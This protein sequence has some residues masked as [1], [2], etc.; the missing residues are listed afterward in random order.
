MTAEKKTNG[1]GEK[2]PARAQAGDKEEFDTLTG[3]VHAQIRNNIIDGLYLPG[4]KLR[5]EHLKRD[6]GVSSSTLREAL[7]MLIADRLVIAEGQR[8]FRVKQVS[9]E[10][11][12]DLNRIRIIL[13]KEAIR[14]SIAHGDEDWEGEVVSSSHILSRATQ[15]VAGNI[16]DQELFDEWE[17]R[18][19]AFHTSL[20]AAAPSE[21]TRYFLTL[22]YQQMERYRRMFQTVAAEHYK[23]RDIQT[24]HAEI[25]DAV[26]ERDADKAAA[27]LEQHLTRTLEEWIAHYE[28]VGEL[29]PVTAGKGQARKPTGKKRN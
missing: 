28:K 18:H 15:A 21:W 3:K 1:N 27:L 17:R 11:L 22:S 25:V 10:D 12:I 16:G 4:E 29:D 5:V 8:G 24:E 19:R 13:E 23:E 26:L 2:K 6:Y 20:F 9:A 14:Q 7:T